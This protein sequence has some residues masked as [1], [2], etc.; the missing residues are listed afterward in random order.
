[1]IAERLVFGKFRLRT[2]DEL[3]PVTDIVDIIDSETAAFLEERDQDVAVDLAEIVLQSFC[4][5]IGADAYTSDAASAAD[6]AVEFC[7]G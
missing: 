4:Q 7:A 3:I 1:M 6:K 2:G 5:Q